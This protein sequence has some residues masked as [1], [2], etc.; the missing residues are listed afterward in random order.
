MNFR[1][2][3][4]LL[5]LLLF[6]SLT[7]T[8]QAQSYVWALGEGGIGNEAA[9]SVTADEAGNVYMTGNLA[10]DGEFSGTDY[11][12]KGLYEVIVAKYDAAGTLQWL[13]MA[14]GKR[15]D[16]GNTIKYANGF[17]YVGGFFEDTA[18]FENTMLVSKG[19]NDAFVAKYDMNGSLVWVQAAGGA[20]LDFVA[21]LDVDAQGN[22]YAGGLYEKAIKFDTTNLSTTNFYQESF[23]CKY[24]SAG[25][26]Q[27][28]KTTRGNNPNQVTGVACDKNGNVYLT[29]FFG[30]N[31]QL[32]GFSTSSNSPSYDIFLARVDANGNAIWLKTAGSA[33]ED[34]ANAIAVDGQG[35]PII[36]GY[37]AHIA[38]FGNNTVTYHDYN[39]IFTAKYDSA[40]NNLWVRAGKGQQLD[41]AYGVAVD[42]DDNIFLTGMF[43]GG[44]SFDGNTMTGGDRDVFLTSYF[45]NGNFRWMTKAGGI[46][47]DCGISLAVKPNGN[48][49]VCGYYLHTG[50]FGSIQ[51]DYAGNNDLFVAEYDPPFVSDVNNL[52]E[53]DAIKAYPN[54]TVNFIMLASK[55]AVTIRLTDLNGKILIAAKFE[56]GDKIPLTDLAAGTYLLHAVNGLK[57]KTFKVQK[58]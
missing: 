42:S 51:V 32:G 47:T 19:S 29:G 53:E 48:I 18:W 8:T 38:T 55:T 40:G 43:Q 16:Q 34:A 26:L 3:I 39:D 27:W 57:T 41:V 17:L 9:N 31:F 13:K 52:V 25:Q 44:V 5:G 28:A 45:P 22:V 12:G 37:F 35:N 21:S 49:A 50:F 20:N 11:F 15:N 6:C 1:H 46:S 4:S 14:G 2:T 36:V 58:Q 54:P 23:Y 30:V 7:I 24:N 56:P 10:G 33:Y